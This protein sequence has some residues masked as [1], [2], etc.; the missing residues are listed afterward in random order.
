MKK[1]VLIIAILVLLS[2]GTI[3][4]FYSRDNN[5]ILDASESNAIITY[6]E[7]LSFEFYENALASEHVE[8]ENGEIKDLTTILDTTKLGETKFELIYESEGKDYKININYTVVDT[9]APLVL[10]SG[11]YTYKVGSDINLVE[12]IFC[13]DNH[14]SKPNCEIIGDY[15]FNVSGSYALQLSAT[16]SSGN[17][18]TKDFN[19]YIKD[20][21]APVTYSEPEKLPIEDVISKHKTDDTRIGIDVSR[22]QEEINWQKVK[23]AG[24][25]FAILRIGY[26]WDEEHTLDPMFEEYFEGASEVGL[27]IGI[28]YYSYAN[29]IEEA[30]HAA[31]WIVDT[32][33]GREL[34]LPI[35]FDWEEWSEFNTYEISLTELNYMA[36]EFI[37]IV[38]DAGYDGMNYGSANYLRNIWDVPQ[39]PTWLA[40]YVDETSYEGDYYMWQLTNTG[41]IDGINTDVDINV[42]YEN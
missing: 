36:I 1:K 30:K 20:Y 18:T 21:I 27:D 35:S 40:H 38:E 14:D 31:N 28:Y 17:N 12:K 2:G 15:D 10:N 23:D 26:G 32:L 4:Y 13:A 29:S 7:N 24:V 34:D 6:D 42:L 37:K 39:Y 19:L 11:S 25:E 8:I 9:T 33:D 22:W 5:T 41:L 16:D 3:L